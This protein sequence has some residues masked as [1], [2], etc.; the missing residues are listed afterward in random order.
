VA[1]KE[2]L[3]AEAIARS[4]QRAG[5]PIEDHERPHA[6]EALDRRAAHSM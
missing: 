1:A 2:R 5:A 4:E 6:V 3:D